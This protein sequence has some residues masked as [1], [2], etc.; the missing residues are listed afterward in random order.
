MAFIKLWPIYSC[1]FYALPIP[2]YCIP[3]VKRNNKEL[4]F[5]QHDARALLS[6]FEA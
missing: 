3:R 4:V 5:M 1:Y 6:S 2:V